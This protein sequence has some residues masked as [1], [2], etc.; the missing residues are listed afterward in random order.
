[1]TQ[2]LNSCVILI[3]NFYSFPLQSSDFTCKWLE[4]EKYVMYYAKSVLFTDLSATL[5]VTFSQVEGTVWQIKQIQYSY[6]K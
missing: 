6:Q 5:T 2:N 3:N 4:A 1:M